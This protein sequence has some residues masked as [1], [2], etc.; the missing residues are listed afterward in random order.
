MSMNALF[1]VCD[2]GLIVGLCMKDY[3]SLCAAVM[4]CYELSPRG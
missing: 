1:L 2:E 4:T 3:M